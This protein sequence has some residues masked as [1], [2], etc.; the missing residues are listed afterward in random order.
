[1]PAKL[2]NQ[3]AFMVKLIRLLQ[4]PTSLNV[5]ADQLAMDQRNVYRWVFILMNMGFKV[6]K[7]ES[8][9]PRKFWI[10]GGSKE[11][12]DVALELMLLSDPKK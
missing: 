1:M 3:L 6:E 10:K 7:S 8:A 9:N 4:Q 12:F 5:L 2:K 11:M